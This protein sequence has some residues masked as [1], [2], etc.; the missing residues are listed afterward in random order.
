MNILDGVKSAE[1]KVSKEAIELSKS[2]KDENLSLIVRIE[3][4]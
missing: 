1:S 3:S 4:F 2:V